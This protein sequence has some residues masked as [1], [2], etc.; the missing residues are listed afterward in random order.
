[1]QIFCS[2]IAD[3]K[4]FNLLKTCSNFEIFWWD[5][6]GKWYKASEMSAQ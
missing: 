1:M 4:Y 6:Y 5:E 2:F 3:F